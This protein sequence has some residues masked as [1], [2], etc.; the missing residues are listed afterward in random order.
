MDRTELQV[1]AAADFLNAGDTAAA[2]RIACELLAKDRNNINALRLMGGVTRQQGDLQQSLEFFQRALSL[3]ER[4]AVLHFELGTAYTELQ[5]SEDAYR[6]YCK[7]VE[8]DR[9]LQPAYVNLSAIMEQHERYDEAIDW[10]LQAIALRPD[11]A[12]SHYNLANA[13]RE[14]GRLDEAIVA[15]R[16]AIDLKP[17]HARTLWNLGICHLL[18]GEFREG[19]QLFELRQDAQE[20]FFDRFAE[21][22]WDGS[23]LTGR[24]VVIHAEQ[25]LGDEV[26]FA[27]CFSDVIRQADQTIVICDPR[28][29]KLFSRSFPT[30]T[31]YGWLRRKDWSPMPVEESVDVQ[32]P[33]GSLPLY[34]RNQPSDF[35]RQAKF[36]IP[37]PQLLAKWRQ[38]MA[39]LGPGLKIGIS[40]RA[41]GKPLESRKRTVPLEQWSDFFA[42]PGVHFVNLQYGDASE[43][44]A[45]AKAKFGVQI[46]D[47]EDADP[48]V[49]VDG[50]A[51]KI[52]AL[53]LVIS[54]GNA[55]VH[56]AG[57]VGTPAWTL[58]PMVPS[59]RWMVAGEESPWYGN[60]RLFRQPQPA[61]WQPVLDRLA[62]MLREKASAAVGRAAG[63]SVNLPA[64][65]EHVTKKDSRPLSRWYGPAELAGHRPD[66]LVGEYIAAAERHEA[67]GELAQAEAAYRQALQLAPRQLV[68]LNG[69][70]VIA[71]KTGRTDLAIRSFRR[72]LS[73]VDALPVH[74]FNLA[75]ALA[76]AARYEEALA[77]YLHGLK[78]EPQHAAAHYQAGRMLVRLKRHAD[79]IEHFHQAVT[80]DPQNADMHVEL[81]RALAM[82]QR[83]DEALRHLEQAVELQPNSPPALDS[84]GEA[85]LEDQQFD[86]AINCFQRAIACEPTYGPAHLHFAQ[87]LEIQGRD[88]DAA[89]AYRQLLELDEGNHSAVLRLA[90]I[91]RRLGQLTEAAASLHRALHIKPADPQ[92]LNTL[93]VVLDEIGQSDDALDCFDDAIQFAPNY[94]EAHVNRALQLLRAGRLSEGWAEY[95]W[96]WKCHGVG[97]APLFSGVPQWDGSPL[98]GK[99]LLISAE[100]G[101]ID[102]LMF[103]SCY[104]DAIEQA[105]RCVIACDP[106]LETLLRRSFPAASIVS[107]LRSA[108]MQLPRGAAIDVQIAA[109]SLPRFLR[110]MLDSFPQRESYLTAEANGVARARA[111]VASLG[112]P[113]RIGLASDFDAPNAA[114][115]SSPHSDQFWAALNELPAVQFV[116]L[117]GS[118]AATAFVRA[119]AKHGVTV[120]RWPG[121]ECT[122]DYDTLAA[123]IAAVD[124][125]LS[126]GGLTAHL[127]G[128]IGARGFVLLNSPASWRWLGAD[129]RTAW[130]PS[131]RIF[132]LARSSRGESANPFMRLREE[133]L[134]L[135]AESADLNR[136]RGISGPHWKTAGDC[137]HFAES[138]EKNWGLSPSPRQF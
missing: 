57:A 89:D 119:A 124:F 92:T 48:L 117:D 113:I 94:A 129:N 104:P 82:T 79:A 23:S 134:K 27:S 49:D 35:P 138:E 137:P 4:K 90:T 31:V 20:V 97:P 128:A 123:R 51:A 67:A 77:R 13:Q 39:A 63:P 116:E 18:R 118:T 114:F 121:A 108:N 99:T 41:G 115:N 21:S 93:G 64:A 24:T 6:C 78:L 102:E 43:E 103:A 110:P 71:R 80:L 72:S 8:L 52:A 112:G 30:A 85:Y 36:L 126:G 10:A 88:A 70:G 132:R 68:A 66:K 136:M 76:D 75:D 19:W 65:S 91:H 122:D 133:L 62:A 135:S 12:L 58:L 22:R 1:K 29:E 50:F 86:D 16:R 46:Y 44:I 33:A 125:V 45:A 59:W 7:A 34:F 37:E 96:R 9:T 47:W 130:H 69:L 61:Q 15:Y 120:H 53:D 60:V 109:G 55:T 106:R 28:L 2:E 32:L 83:L 127:A 42:K 25:G 107:T 81:G 95:E 11:C 73:M 100:Q 3:N 74:Q 40:W 26:L 14:L 87:A 5:Q 17:G 111:E 101:L 56:I 54:V 84:L 38:R 131:L 105:Q 98:T